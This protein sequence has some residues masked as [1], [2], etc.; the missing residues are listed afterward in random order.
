MTARL[1]VADA[2]VVVEVLRY[3]LAPLVQRAWAL[4]DN[5]ALRDGLYVA[6][7]ETLGATLLTLDERLARTAPG[8]VE[9]P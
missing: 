6:C 1:L 4:R 5:I 2:S 7:A 3:P 8:P 9:T